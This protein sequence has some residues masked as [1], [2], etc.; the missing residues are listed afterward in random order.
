MVFLYLNFQKSC[1]K[2]QY[3]RGLCTKCSPHFLFVI[4]NAKRVTKFKDHYFS[5]HDKLDLECMD[6]Q[7]KFR[8]MTLLESHKCRA[9]HPD[10]TLYKPIDASSDL[11]RCLGRQSFSDLHTICSHFRIAVPGDL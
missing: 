5:D 4:P 7:Q 11:A 9:R 8:Q 1:P 6:C 2:V 10:S 3:Y